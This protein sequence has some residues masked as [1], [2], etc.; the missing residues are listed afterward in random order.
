MHIGMCLHANVFG[1]SRCLAC[2]AASTGYGH[3]FLALS[4]LPFYSIELDKPTMILTAECWI[5]F[6]RN[7]NI[8]IVIID[9]WCATNLLSDVSGSSE[10]GGYIGIPEVEP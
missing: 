5:G 10:E 6:G 7:D 4:F 1:I 9:P 3:I 2:H 8:D